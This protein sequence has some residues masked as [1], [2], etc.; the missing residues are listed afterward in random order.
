MKNNIENES[1]KFLKIT[2]RKNKTKMTK[3]ARKM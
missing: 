3:T 1:K 2:S